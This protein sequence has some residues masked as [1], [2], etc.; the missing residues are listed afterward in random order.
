MNNLLKKQQIRF[1]EIDF[2][3]GLAIITMIISHVFYFM[4]NMDMI[5]LNYN[6]LWYLFLT[7]FA[8][9]TFITCIGINLSLSYQKYRNDQKY[10]KDPKYKGDSFY[11]KQIKRVLIIGFF[12]LILS[13]L[14]YLT[15]G[16]KFIKFGIL[17]FASCAIL[18]LMWT[19]KYNSLTITILALVSFIYLVK[20]KLIFWSQRILNPFIIFIIGIYNPK[21]YSLDYFPIIPWLNYSCIGILIG[22][23]FYKNYQRRYQLSNK[24]NQFLNND[25]NI[26]S[27]FIRVFGKYSFLIYLIHLPILYFILLLIKK[28]Y[29]YHN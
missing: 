4:N 17:H 16:Y 26:G 23:F 1:N 8:Q 9:T 24:L 15:H 18:I 2:V 12:A 28:N 7:L 3:K 22:N 6:S 25:K 11:T 27:K 21:Y 13:Y 19:V 29:N 20:D 14:T 5:S 10:K